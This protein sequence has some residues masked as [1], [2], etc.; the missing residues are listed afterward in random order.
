LGKKSVSSGKNIPQIEMWRVVGVNKERATQNERGR[1]LRGFK[2]NG[3]SVNVLTEPQNQRVEK[4]KK[5]RM[6]EWEMRIY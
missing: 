2:G 6:R 4:W 1:S 5:T 3:R